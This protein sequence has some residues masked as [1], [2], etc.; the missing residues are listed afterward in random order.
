MHELKVTLALYPIGGKNY[1]N[2]CGFQQPAFSSQVLH[3]GAVGVS[4]HF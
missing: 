2:K 4:G 1:I 3:A